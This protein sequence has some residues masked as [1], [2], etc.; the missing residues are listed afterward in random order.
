MNYIFQNY[1]EPGL[2]VDAI[3]LLTM[4]LNP[5][6]TWIQST[7]LPSTAHQDEASIKVQLSLFPNPSEKL[8]LFVF[9]SRTRPVCYLT[10]LLVKSLEKDFDNFAFHNFLSFLDDIELVKNSLFSHYLGFQD[11]SHV[12]IESIIRRDD[13]LPDKIKVLLFGF[14]L[15]PEKY[16]ASL[17]KHL[18]IY[19]EK[20]SALNRDLSYITLDSSV[21]RSLLNTYLLNSC[22]K[23]T[24]RFLRELPSPLIRYSICTSV[25]NLF[26]FGR[27]PY[28]WLILTE[29]T[30]KKL[31]E[32][33][34]VISLDYIIHLGEALRN[35][36]RVAI[37]RQLQA[38]H[39]LVIEELIKTTGL[40][41]STLLHHLS[42]MKK[43]RLITEHKKGKQSIYSFH[44]DGFLYA[45][46]TLANIALEAK[47]GN[48][49][50][51]ED[52]TK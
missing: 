10:D 16:I 4:K 34:A 37:I 14:I 21:L 13:S 20:L 33:P 29:E 30:I 26:Y 52:N 51:P 36:T 6:H 27:A 5:E 31:T 38:K 7:L 41:T 44:Q 17:K 42:I 35:P 19:Y 50:L 47:N 40:T 12:D 2:A 45:S 39:E 18:I 3:K 46:K 48:S 1:P 22:I 8:Y 49:S 9:L 25:P 28:L 23:D 24:E 11:Y 43:A 32:S 15:K